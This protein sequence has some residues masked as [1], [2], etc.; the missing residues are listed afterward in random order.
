LSLL[1]NAAMLSWMS[2]FVSADSP[3]WVGSGRRG[4]RKAAAE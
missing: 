1:R 2:A 4:N 3:Q